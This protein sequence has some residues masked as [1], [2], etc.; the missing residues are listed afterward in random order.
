MSNNEIER[1]IEIYREVR[2]KKNRQAKVAKEFGVTRQRV[3]QIVQQFDRAECDVYWKFNKS[4][5][6]V[7]YKGIRNW[8]RENN[9]SMT[10]FGELLNQKRPDGIRSFLYGQANGNINMIRDILDVTGLTFEEAFAEG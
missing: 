6:Q 1:N 3:S 4:S 5:S 7:I 9:L 8:M 10:A 2:Q